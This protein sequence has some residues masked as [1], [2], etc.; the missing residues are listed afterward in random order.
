M[1]TIS[2]LDRLLGIGTGGL[3]RVVIVMVRLPDIITIGA[4]TE[5]IISVITTCRPR[6]H[7]QVGQAEV[8]QEGINGKTGIKKYKLCQFFL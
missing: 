8:V 2:T 7:G 1:G 5:G 6:G 3:H 4:L